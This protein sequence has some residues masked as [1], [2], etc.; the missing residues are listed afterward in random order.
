M[1]VPSWMTPGCGADKAE[2]KGNT[3]LESE[4]GQ[5][6]QEGQKAGSYWQGQC[7]PF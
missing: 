2:G 3:G 5:E 7:L 1:R 4:P 6:G